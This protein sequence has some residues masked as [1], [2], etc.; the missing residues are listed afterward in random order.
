MSQGQF[1]E[2][3]FKKFIA[4]NFSHTEFSRISTLGAISDLIMEGCRL[5]K[6]NSFFYR[7][8]F[9]VFVPIL[10]AIWQLKIIIILTVIAHSLY[11]LSVSNKPF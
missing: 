5:L 8:D 9:V 2:A 3:G 6:F 10:V 1:V 4:A 11:R 7:F